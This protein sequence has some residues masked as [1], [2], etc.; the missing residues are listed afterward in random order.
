VALF[1]GFAGLVSSRLWTR[2]CGGQLRE[3]LWVWGKYTLPVSLS[4][5][6][7]PSGEFL[8]LLVV[9]N[10]RLSFVRKLPFMAKNCALAN[11]L[12]SSSAFKPVAC[13][14]IQWRLFFFF[15]IQSRLW[16]AG[17]GIPLLSC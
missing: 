10:R 17:I 6:I 12:C 8:R 1:W 16:C 7:R 9:Q 13:G 2:G 14:S 3:F 11:V 5:A 4:F 15:L